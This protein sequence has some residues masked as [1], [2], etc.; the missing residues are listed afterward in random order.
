MQAAATG[1]VRVPHVRGDVFS[2]YNQLHALGLR[3]ALPHGLTFDLPSPPQ[4]VAIWP[5]AGRRV[6]PGSVVTLYLARGSG[7]AAASAARGRL[8]RYRVPQLVGGY[9]S[10]AYRW[11]G[12]KRLIFRAY[13]APLTGGSAPGLLA[14]YL[15]TRQQPA[16][17][18]R[19][20]LGQ[21]RKGIHGRGQ[22]FRETP[23]S[24][25]GRPRPPV[26]ATGPASAI[27]QTGAA[28]S[29]AV[30][31]VG[32]STTYYFDYGPTTTYGSTSRAQQAGWGNVPIL[33]TATLSDLQPATIY[34]YRLVAKSSAATVYG[35]DMTF[36]SA[37]FYQNPL[38]TGAAMPDPFVLDNGGLHDDYWAYGTGDRFPMLHSTDLVNWTPVGTAMTARPNWVTTAPDWHPWGPSVMSSNQPCP[39]A[40]SGGCYIMYYTGLSAQLN[41]NCVAV[42]TSPSPGGPF[43][44]QG[45]LDLVSGATPGQP[46]GCGDASG[47]GN[48]DPSPFIDTTGQPYL[49][50]ST[51][52]SC[53]AGSCS[54]APTISV[55][56][57]TTDYLHAA[58]ARIPLF[59]GT[60]GSWEAAGS[61]V[62]NVEG[63]AMELHNGTYYL[64]YSGG[65]Y[66]AAYGMGYATSSSPTGPF[67]KAA[68]P[69]LTQTAA[70]GGP[71]GG[72]QLVTGPHGGQWLV[73]H[74]RSSAGTLRTLRLDSVTWTP[75][76]SAGAPDTPTINGPT[77]TPQPVQP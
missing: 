20:A 8:P 63:P 67:T 65:N 34:H 5:G 31:P 6:K 37:G 56:P 76:A 39:G 7:T 36:T 14:N 15:V 28:V 64:L 44:D 19:L 25:W 73:Y 38:Y 52:D 48:I 68:A 27:T 74:G 62:P 45:P 57:L 69:I 9:V 16:P 10:D 2:V 21:R 54:H 40:T 29:G 22:R 61:S 58:A 50:V 41:V 47:L 49:Y 4:V 1:R 70:V 51:T 32:E 60:P 23:L 75:A 77:A 59:T 18:T 66:G 71:G 13:L 30:D 33:V 53:A 12:H 43:V 46:L 72:D 35:T 55:I 11:V 3:V 24:I 42:A 26:T 17:G